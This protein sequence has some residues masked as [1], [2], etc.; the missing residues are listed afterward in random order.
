M[1][2]CRPSPEPAVAKKRTRRRSMSSLPDISV[3]P[4]PIGSR[5]GG[6][7]TRAPRIVAESL[8]AV[9]HPL[10]TG[11]AAGPRASGAEVARAL[12][13]SLIPA[14][15]DACPPPWL[16]PGQARSFRRALAALQR[17]GGALLADPV[18]SG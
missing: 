10:L 2:S 17:Y 6:S 11:L 16:L 7:W 4:P 15:A 13:R 18:G 1:P 9:R 14:E 3:S 5:S 12:V 8:V